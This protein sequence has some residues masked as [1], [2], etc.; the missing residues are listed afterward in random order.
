MSV[1]TDQRFRTGEVCRE[2]GRYVFDSYVDGS[3]EPRPPPDQSSISLAA[4]ERF[5][6]IRGPRRGRACFWRPVGEAAV[7]EE[8]VAI[9]RMESEGGG[10]TEAGLR[11]PPALGQ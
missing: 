9:T 6:S 5:P 10:V 8:D 7:D 1:H 4:G 11:S 2:P 3:A